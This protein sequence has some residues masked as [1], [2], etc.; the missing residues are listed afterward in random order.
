MPWN[1]ERTLPK[2]FLYHA[3]SIFPIFLYVAKSFT[4]KVVK[5]E[6]S[7]RDGNKLFNWLLQYNSNWLDGILAG[8]G[9]I[10]ATKSIHIC[11]LQYQIFSDEFGVSEW[12]L[13]LDW[14]SDQWAMFLDALCIQIVNCWENISTNICQ[15]WR[16]I[17]PLM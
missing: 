8:I 10:A 17:Y 9:N 2:K 15:K 13:R 6:G 4:A 16:S 11:I 14:G 7:K 12:L 1:H 3:M 5:N